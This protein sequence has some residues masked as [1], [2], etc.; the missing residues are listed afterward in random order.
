MHFVSCMLKETENTCLVEGDLG[1]DCCE[2]MNAKEY[3]RSLSF[4]DIGLA[5]QLIHKRILS[6][7]WYLAQKLLQQFKHFDTIPAVSLCLYVQR[8]TKRIVC[9]VESA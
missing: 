7:L 2:K 9:F 3:A 4:S 1:K 5:S 8:T 6:Y